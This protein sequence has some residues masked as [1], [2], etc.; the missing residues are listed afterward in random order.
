MTT[1]KPQRT[2]GK[3]TSKSKP[4]RNW[5]EAAAAAGRTQAKEDEVVREKRD[6][7]AERKGGMPLDRIKP[8]GLDTRRLNL[9]HVTALA[10]SIRALGLLEPLVVDRHG[11]LLA[12]G[13]RLGA[14]QHLQRNY[15]DDF[16]RQFP[17][18]EVPVRVLDMDA[19]AEPALAMDIEVAENECRRDYTQSE[20]RH[21]VDR[22]QKAGYRN[23][24]G[25][26]RPDDKPLKDALGRIIGKSHRTVE[27][28]L[29]DLRDPG[30]KDKT[31]DSLRAQELA[32]LETLE[33]VVRRYVGFAGRG[34][35][36]ADDNRNSLRVRLNRALT[37]AAKL[38]IEL[39][40][41]DD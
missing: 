14:I 9:D 3:A 8:R 31:G 35:L 33:Q 29:A 24:P 18:G 26:P 21:I 20:L 6:A 32:L 27:R 38:R 7:V 4:A 2:A 36:P 16:A 13:H 30:P 5:G 22:L 19:E 34:D 10:G 12:G 25:R 28:L 41:G 17:L 1:K 40:I 11:R 37:L 23:R 39:G 15:P